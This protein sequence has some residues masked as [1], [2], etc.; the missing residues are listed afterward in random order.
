M[1]RIERWSTRTL[2]QMIAGMLY[3]RTAI[4]KKPDKLIKQELKSLHDEDKLTPDLL[5]HD[6]YFLDFL[7]LG[8]TYSSR[9]SMALLIAHRWVQPNDCSQVQETTSGHVGG[10]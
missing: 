8:D 4:S 2:E 3:E 6:P 9:L 1:S 10:S 5:F 7:A